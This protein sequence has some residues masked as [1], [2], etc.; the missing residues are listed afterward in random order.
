MKKNGEESLL[1][2]L[3]ITNE[4]AFFISFAQVFLPSVFFFF[5]LIKFT[6][7]TQIQYKSRGSMEI[8]N[9]P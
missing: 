4:Q 9:N 7:T 1:P 2:G 3:K 5:I 6:I 8:H